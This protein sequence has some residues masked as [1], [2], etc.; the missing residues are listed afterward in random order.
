MIQRIQ[1]VYLILAGLFNL[2]TFFTPIYSRAVADPS[3][4]IGKGLAISMTVAMFISF[5]SIFLYNNRMIQIRWVKI[6]V[7]CQI[8]SMGFAA[9]VLFSLGGFGR[10]MINETISMLLPLFALLALWQ[11]GKDIKKDQELVESM[12]RIR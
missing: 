5:I 2:V 7:I 1:T 8:I 9:G 11:A 10:F 6:A 3:A 4:W 12:N